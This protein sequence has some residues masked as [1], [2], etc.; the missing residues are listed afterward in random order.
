MK[1]SRLLH[2]VPV[3]LL[4]TLRLLG[5]DLGGQIDLQALKQGLQ[6]SGA[7]GSQG[8]DAT[9]K[10][11]L[12]KG[13]SAE[14]QKV[15][16][17]RERQD[18]TVE[19]E[20]RQ[21]KAREKG[22]RRFA[23][24]LFEFRSAQLPTTEGGI[25]ED[26]VLGTGDQ[27]QISVFGSATFE[28]SAQVDGRG[29]V[30]IPKV[31]A[32]KVSG[33]PLAK[34]RAA[35][36]SKVAQNFSR[37]TLDLSVTKLREVRAFVLGEVYKPGSY[38]VPSLSSLVNVL[39]LA[40]GPTPVGSFRQIRVIRGG[41]VV[42]ALDLYPL[43]AEGLGNM[44]VSLQSGDSIFVPLAFNQ[45]LL[46]GAFT[47]VVAEA[48]VAA[49]AKAHAKDRPEEVDENA[50]PEAQRTLLRQIRR[51]EA[52]LGNPS[53][54]GLPLAT[55]IQAGER[56][57]EPEISPLERPAIEEQLQE[58]REKLRELKVKLR[59]DQRVPDQEVAVLERTEQPQWLTRWQLEGKVP[60]MQFEA[61]PGET[62]A[63]LLR[64]A[65]GFATQA[66]QER[67]SLRRLD[68]QGVLQVMDVAVPQGAATTKLERGDVL[69]A[70]PLRD[71]MGRS[72]QVQGW[73][74]VPG[75]FAR[76]E[77]L[78]VGDLLRRENQLLPDTYQGRGE[79]V[80][81]AADGR[82]S[83]VAF[84]V[85]KALAGDPAHN[86]LMEDRDRVDLYRI[87]DLR[88]RRTVKVVGPV[89][90][91]GTFDFHEG[92][93]A[94]DLLFRAGVQ[95]RQAD[96]LVAELAHTRDGKPS[97][98]RTLDLT[99]LL[100]TEQGSPVDLKDDAINPRLEP[101]DQL[102]VFEKPDYRPHRVVKLSGQVARPGSYSLDKDGMGLADLLARAGGLTREAMPEG[103]IFL[104]R[105]GTLD[106][107]K[108]K[109]L[110]L[111]GVESTDPTG[112]GINEILGRLA[113]TKRQPITGQLLK[114]PMLHGLTIGTTTRMVVN[115][116]GVLK[117][118]RQSDVTL[119]DGDEIVIPRKSDSA[120]VVGEVASPFASF[121]LK[122]GMSVRELLR[123]AGG[124]TR[125]ADT[126]NIRLLKADG[127]I[128]DSWVSGR[129]VEP[130]DAVLVPSKVRR[131]VSWQENLAA[132]TNLAVMYAAIK[133]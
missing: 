99:R 87:D 88:E 120:Y 2:S 119:Q 10:S 108:I 95:L 54:N 70:L 9:P 100:S 36:Q 116:P 35:L 25:A 111:A 75:A 33:L 98:V 34:A 3:L 79:I 109:A 40:G 114:T 117:G 127:R 51:L 71:L 32:V 39:G 4:G 46:E 82:T 89:T 28:V 31:G 63:D 91:P 125:N 118:E 92:M 1:T 26:Y 131:D 73:V 18:R 29:E 77:G 85:A 47:R 106:P 133:D 42:H 61:L 94:A 96:R 115:L 38:L 12:P 6:A 104:R 112:N 41:K 57:K 80:R 5:Q 65:G 45:I 78:R 122:E 23:S 102:S 67:L 81:T 103:T 130:G 72:V 110:E 107:E 90:R 43:R 27:L 17:L 64:F 8:L 55:S 11:V 30:I 44:N 93:R 124:T 66:F 105:L 48:E 60:R 58:L 21:M 83:Y 132:I 22:P 86:L 49:Q 13:D 128:L 101:L 15:Q 113:E 24:D 37:T 74:R 52:R 123:L 68:A 69:S 59:G 16:T 14:A 50:L 7:T 62:A 76:P 97:E 84:D 126:W 19:E 20:I 53:G 56:Q 129:K 121:R